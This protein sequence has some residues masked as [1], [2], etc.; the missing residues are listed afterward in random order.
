MAER[1]ELYSTTDGGEHTAKT[2]DM[3][4]AAWAAVDAI[5]MAHGTR[6][7][8]KDSD[9]PVVGDPE[10]GTATLVYLKT[11]DAYAMNIDGASEASIASFKEATAE[12][13]T[14]EAKAEMSA[15]VA[16]YRE[17]KAAE[18][19]KEPK[20]AKEPKA[21]KEPKEPELPRSNI[22]VFPLPVEVEGDADPKKAASAAMF[23]IADAAIEDL[24]L[25]GTVKGS[26]SPKEKAFVLGGRGLSDENVAAIEEKMAAYRTPEA[27]AAW[28]ANAPADVAKASTA[29]GPA[30][31]EGPD[32]AAAAA[33]EAGT[34]R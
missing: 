6:E 12:F 17:G 24:G 10:K 19:P 26:Y 21:P 33:K 5:G 29:K 15:A 1:I 16:A 23:K 7:G 22:R 11:Q 3:K 13:R 4:K 34:G 18:G 25:T 14:P 27:E 30:E 31:A 9:K 20:A 8:A 32:L 2:D 28:R